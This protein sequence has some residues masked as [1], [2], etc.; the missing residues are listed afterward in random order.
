MK[1]KNFN[2]FNERRIDISEL[3]IFS[4]KLVILKEHFIAN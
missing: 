1:G 2:S 3:K 4:V